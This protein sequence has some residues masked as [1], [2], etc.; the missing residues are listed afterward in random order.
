M[1][2]MPHLALT[3]AP[4]SIHLHLR[5]S[6]LPSQAWNRHSWL[7]GKAWAEGRGVPQ[8]S[9]CY[10]HRLCAMRAEW[11]QMTE[12]VG[13]LCPKASARLLCGFGRHKKTLFKCLGL[14]DACLWS[15]P[16]H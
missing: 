9:A 4:W 10:G 6:S 14:G 16:R 15:L 8:Q 3:K 7:R 13:D 1:L 11:V 2:P 12:Q 5:G